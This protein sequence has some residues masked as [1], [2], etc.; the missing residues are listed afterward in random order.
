M[1]GDGVASRML[2]NTSLVNA[3]PKDLSAD[4]TRLAAVLD[5]QVGYPT[6]ESF[7]VEC[8]RE[9]IQIPYRIYRPII[10]D[11]VF[12]GLALGDR[13]IAACWFTRHHDGHMR[14]RF[15]RALPA[16]DRSWIVAYV[17]TLCGEYVAELLEYIWERRDLF[18]RAILARWL[19]ENETFHA[20]TRRRIVSYWDCYYRGRHPSFNSYV[21][22]Q[23]IDF[24][25]ECVAGH[26]SAAPAQGGHG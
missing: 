7:A 18:D 12:A 10:P 11:K 24:F 17:V 20:R 23:L 2:V 13:L 3:F 9:A 26:S 4:V 16:F 8:E 1:A 19:C 22:C 25:E 6:S 15:L 21:G 14:E 5:P